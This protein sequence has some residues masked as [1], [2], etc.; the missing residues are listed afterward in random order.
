MSHFVNLKHDCDTVDHFFAFVKMFRMNISAVTLPYILQY[1]SGVITVSDY[2]V[3]D[4][5]RMVQ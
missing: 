1:A 5:M 4:A 2:E 3:I